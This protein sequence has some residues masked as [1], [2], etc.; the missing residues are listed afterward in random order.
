MIKISPSILS[1][2]FARLGEE[3]KAVSEAGADYIHV[4]VMDGHF[5]PN[6]TIGPPVVK[7][8]RQHT[9]LPLDVH[10]M[11][12]N[13]DQFIDEFAQAGADFIGVHVEACTHLNRTLAHIKDLGKKP[14]V[15]L[16]PATPVVSIEN[17]LDMVDMILIMS[18]NPGFGGQKFIR[19]S[20][21]KVMQLDGLLTMRSLD[22]PIQVDGGI[23][24]QTIEP[25]ASAGATVFVS[26][27]G[28][29]TH[30]GGYA[31]AMDEM[32]QEAGRGKD[33]V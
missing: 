4:D 29:F 5:V 11:M 31:A 2:D 12:D 33:F 1:A 8:L 26:G 18:V 14:V 13:P 21:D 23:T 10:L 6:L 15:V 32:R 19:S 27:T 9:D 17:V 28:V 16:N 25:V 3:V 24:A 22:V 30:P 7:C 20:V